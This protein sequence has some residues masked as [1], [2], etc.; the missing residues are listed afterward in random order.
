MYVEAEKAA[1]RNVYVH[2]RYIEDVRKL[3]VVVT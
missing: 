1:L 3:S 2:C